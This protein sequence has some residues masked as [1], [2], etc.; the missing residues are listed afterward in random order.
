M[1]NTN[2]LEKKIDYLIARENY[3][4][5]LK[6]LPILIEMINVNIINKHLDKNINHINVYDIIDIYRLNDKKRYINMID[7]S[8]LYEQV[9]NKEISNKDCVIE[10]KKLYTQLKE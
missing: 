6:V 9:T 3:N 1:Y 10:L 4:A 2:S 7:I 8:Y 5:A